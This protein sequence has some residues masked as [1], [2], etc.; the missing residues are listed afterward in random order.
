MPSPLRRRSRAYRGVRMARVYTADGN[1]LRGQPTAEL[2]AAL[3]AE[4]GCYVHARQRPGPGGWWEL[5]AGND[6]GA[7]QVFAR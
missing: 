6:A 5:A 2:L 4:P 1:R 3:D 7:L